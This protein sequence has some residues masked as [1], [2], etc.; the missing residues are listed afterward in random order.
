M[1]YTPIIKTKDFCPNPVVRLKIPEYADGTNYP[2]VIGTRLH[3]EFWDEQIDRCLNGYTTGGIH[4]PGRY[5]WYLNFCLISS[6]GRG[7]HAP[8]YVDADLEYFKLVDQIKIDHMG[9]IALKARRRGLSEKWAKGIAGYGVRFTPEK[10]RAGITAGLKDHSEGLFSKIKELNG[11]LPIE[12]QLGNIFDNNSDIEYGWQDAATGSKKGSLNSITCQTMNTNPNVLKGNFFNDVA[13]EESGE[14]PN[15]IKG[16]GATK[17]CF[18]VGNDMIGTPYVYGTGGN[19]ASGSEGFA[20]MW[21]KPWNYGLVKFELFAQR[22]MVGYFIGSRNEKGEL[23]ENCPN[24]V[25]EYPGLTRN[26]LLGCED[27]KASL[28]HVGFKKAELAK[29]VDKQP[30]Y[31]YLQNMP[32]SAN[33]AFLKFSGNNFN[34]EILAAQDIAIKTLTMPKY[35]KYQLEFKRHEDGSLVIPLEIGEVIELPDETPDDQAILILKDAHPR[36]YVKNLDVGGIDSYDQDVT[37]TSKS[38]GAMTVYRRK[39]NFMLHS[40]MP[41]ALIRMRPPRKEVFYLN[42][43]KLSVYFNLERNVQGDLRTPAIMKFF[44]E[45]HGSRFLAKRPQSIESENS[46]Q[47]H[48]FWT[49]L[50]VHSKPLMIGYVQTDILDNGHKWWFPQHVNEA[51][52]YDVKQRDSDWDAVDSLGLAKIQDVELGSKKMPAPISSATVEHDYGDEVVE[53]DG[54]LVPAGVGNPDGTSGQIHRYANGNIITDLLTRHMLD[55]DY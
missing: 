33:E 15:L 3:S 43:L 38:L 53:R 20:E 1:I 6:I 22:L 40:E 47:V 51:Q 31:D 26:E 12:M 44:K 27:V 13:F 54:R 55:N 35:G 30:Y 48:E 4:I 5:Y 34:P 24:L 46:E 16:Y 32:T 2:E 28:E 10:Y 19:I 39:N 36:L 49:S 14:F 17:D 37:L 23:N 9:L 11:L 18:S 29:S 25:K 7:F 41:I 8:D 52:D 42:C 50:N 45:N 21:Y